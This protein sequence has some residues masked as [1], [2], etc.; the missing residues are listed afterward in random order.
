VMSLAERASGVKELFEHVE[1][2]WDSYVAE[3]RRTLRGVGA[4][5]PTACREIKRA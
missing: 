3:V 5:A 1:R 2:L 4:P